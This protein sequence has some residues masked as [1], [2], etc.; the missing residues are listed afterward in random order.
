MMKLGPRLAVLVLALLAPAGPA[1]AADRTAFVAGVE[2]LPLVPG[3]KVVSDT[4]VAFDAAAGRIVEAYA[5]GP[6]TKR[7]VLDFY[8]QTLPQLG[9]T[10]ERPDRF[11]RQG[12]ALQ[13]DF[14][15]RDQQLTVRF[16][17][18]PQ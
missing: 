18:A 3:M 4:V 5:I 8:G 16:T 12:E 13:L 6:L 15:G 11:L 7:F 14:F 2:D 10:A 1:P 17:V 9:W